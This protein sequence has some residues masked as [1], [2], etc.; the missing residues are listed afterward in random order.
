MYCDLLLGD[1]PSRPAR[2]TPLKRPPAP[3][4]SG[5][6]AGKGP[7]L[8]SSS[9]FKKKSPKNKQQP[10][11]RVRTPD[12]DVEEITILDDDSMDAVKRPRPDDDSDVDSDV[13]LE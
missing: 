11:K 6:R 13:S 9:I 2:T 5:N 4:N 10:A 12:S 7:L 1:D 3:A 8:V